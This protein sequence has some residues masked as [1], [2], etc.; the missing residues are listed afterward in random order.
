M[1]RQSRISRRGLIGG[2]AALGA[3]GLAGS[4][5]VAHAAPMRPERQ[6]APDAR[7]AAQLPAR[8]EFVVRN[9]WVLTMDPA[10][11]DLERG[12]VHVRNG[13]IVAV[14]VDLAA[15]GAQVIDGRNTIAL[16]GFVDTHWHL[17]NSHM[18]TLIQ[19]GPQLGY[20]PVVL[21][22]GLQ[23]TP[24]DT[25]RS[26]RLGVVEGIYS[27]IT[28]VHDWSHNSRS[29]AHIDANLR[30]LADTGI[31][32]RFS[33][34]P[35]QGIPADEPMNLADL[36]RVANEWASW[37][38]GGLLSLG[39]ASRGSNQFGSAFVA[40]PEVIRRE[41]DAARTVG[42]PITIHASTAGYAETFGR[43]G[44]LGP[45]VQFVHGV[46][47]TAADREWMATTG[48]HLSV[49]PYTEL[50]ISMA[51]PL[52]TDMLD[53]GVLTSLSFDATSIPGNSDMFST[54]RLAADLEHL[55][56][57]D[58]MSAPPRKI[59]EMATIDGARDLGL[60]D[61][62]GS[63]TPGKRADLILVRTTDL[64]MAP[65]VDP[66]IAL[67]HCA[68]PHN[69]DTVVIDGRILKRGGQL[70]VFDTEK[71]VAEAV[72]S[73]EGLRARAGDF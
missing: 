3:A 19:D 56:T 70:T 13:E 20:F 28:T 6:R 33:Y 29:P 17:W 41:W 26:V 69:V 27:G 11:G 4:V 58:V 18:R 53:A 38:N 24:E 40:Q 64:N 43:E 14:G 73:L 42:A 67:V 49:S 37:S 5:D 36:R 30:A 50:R 51:P 47:L 66:V 8:G 63:L 62:T 72:E 54:M 23:Y 12:E 21:R 15:P 57:R 31:R 52:I 68:Q 1:G 48:T 45:D 39:M 16:P 7:P 60:A 9:A 46:S 2:A 59:L 65:V 10:L 32:G 35:R 61:R 55:R 25:Y 71:I 34:G 44:W 22:L